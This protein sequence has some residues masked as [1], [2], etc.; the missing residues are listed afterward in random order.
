MAR[1]HAGGASLALAAPVDALFTATE[2]NEW[3]LC[4]TLY[5]QDGGR[6]GGLEAALVAAAL[7]DAAVPDLELVPVL[8]EGAA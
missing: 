3:A 4:A 1:T 6:W 8:A 2:V 7:E 5:A